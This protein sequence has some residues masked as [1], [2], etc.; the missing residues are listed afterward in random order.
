ME[1]VRS[2]INFMV[3]TL[4][5]IGV[6]LLGG[7][8]ALSVRKHQLARRVIGISRSKESLE[9]ARQRGMIDEGRLEIDEVFQSASLAII[10]TPVDHVASI[11]KSLLAQ[12]PEIIVSDVGST[13]ADIVREMDAAGPLAARFIGGHPMAG[14]EKIGPEHATDHLFQ[15]RLMF[16]SPSTG[17][18]PATTTLLTQFWQ[19][20]GSK[21][22]EMEADEHDAV[23]AMTSHLPHLASYS[24]ANVT[25]EDFLQ[26]SGT[27]MR[28]MTRLAGGDP[29]MWTAIAMSNR[30]HLLKGLE[31]YKQSLLQFEQALLGGDTARLQQLFTQGKRTHH[32]LGS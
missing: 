28:T 22:I 1:A 7:S 20:L 24:L 21:V 9:I 16:L 31:L 14:S 2:Y 27:G 12:F 29:T 3:D 4:A 32:A 23:M 6:G 25:P 30:Q 17:T 5:I 26:Y 13:K 19:A 18:A 8:I 15:H 11:A 10:C